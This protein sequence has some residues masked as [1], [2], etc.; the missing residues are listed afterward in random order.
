MSAA[1]SLRVASPSLGARGC[2]GRQ[3]TT[4]ANSASCIE[5]RSLRIVPNFTKRLA[6]S[7]TETEKAQWS[8]A[9]T[10]TRAFRTIAAVADAAADGMYALCSELVILLVLTTRQCPKPLNR[11]R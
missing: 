10:G 3:S 9:R 6:G 11:Y 4:V 2:G 5:V 8:I 1:M 7:F